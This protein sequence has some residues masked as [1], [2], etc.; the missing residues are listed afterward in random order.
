MEER[1]TGN[2]VQKDSLNKVIMARARSGTFDS[3]VDRKTKCADSST[4]IKSILSM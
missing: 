2:T 4:I 3:Q 1:S